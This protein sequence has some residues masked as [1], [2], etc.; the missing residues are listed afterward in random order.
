MTSKKFV[1][2]EKHVEHEY[3][4]KGYGSKRA[5]YIGKAVAGKVARERR[6]KLVRV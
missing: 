3:E 4:K 2:L 6:K 1:R 5:E